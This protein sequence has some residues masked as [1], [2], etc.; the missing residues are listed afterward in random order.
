MLQTQ[1]T[2]A[3]QDA[4]QSI[5]NEA[6][7][8]LI[9]SW[10][11]LLLEEFTK[12]YMKDLK[13][14][15]VSRYIAQKTVYPQKSQIFNALNITSFESVK[16][17]LLGQDPYH[18]PF[19]AH[20]LSFSVNKGVNLPPSLKNIFQELKNDLN[21]ENSQY[22]DLSHWAKQGVLLLNSILT[23]ERGKP[24]SHQNR[25]WERFTDVIIQKLNG[26]RDHLVFLLWGSYARNKG[27][28]ID[29][30]KHLVLAAPHPSPFSAHKGFF[31]SKPFSKIN[32]Y[33]TRRHQKPIDW[34]N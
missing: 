19:Q 24:G 30:T 12:D 3:I 33:L 25:G 28:F 27:Q 9:D 15:L 23:V 21:I 22:G 4:H 10:K 20:G 16:V 32:T 26:K 29:T 5:V 17:V 7:I 31:G 34:S 11:E 13:S 2:N 18:G 8:G 6:S 1:N 14:F